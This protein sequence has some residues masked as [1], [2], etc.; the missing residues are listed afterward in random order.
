MLRGEKK[1]HR[2]RKPQQVRKSLQPIMLI[3]GR[4][5]Q[6]KV[7]PRVAPTLSISSVDRL[8]LLR[9]NLW[10]FFF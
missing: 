5:S 10:G 2:E 8:F 4:L 3:V 6:A 9:C 1:K 7:P